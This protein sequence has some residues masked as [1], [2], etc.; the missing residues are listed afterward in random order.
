MD[1]SLR[2]HHLFCIF[3]FQRKGYSPDFVENFQKVLEKIQS[4][5]ELPIQVTGDTDSI[6]QACPHRN[7]KN[8]NKGEL[9]DKEIR[10]MDANV[11]KVLFSSGHKLESISYSQLKEM[12]QKNIQKK[13]QVQSVC[14][15]CDWRS[16]CLFY[17]NL[18]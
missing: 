17:S 7:N 3:G 14:G 12:V 11:R 13:E 5:P 1:L 9:A 8:C 4:N 6:C 18:E 16:S 2:P 10:E 15:A